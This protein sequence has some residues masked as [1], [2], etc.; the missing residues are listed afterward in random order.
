ML[1]AIAL[2]AVLLAGMWTAS[3]AGAIPIT[4]TPDVVD[5]Q[6]GG[7]PL[8]GTM[9]ITLQSGET[10][11]ATTHLALHFEMTIYD[12]EPVGNVAFDVP[13]LAPLPGYGDGGMRIVDTG[14]PQNA[15]HWEFLGGGP[16]EAGSATILVELA[17]VPT[18]AEFSVSGTSSDSASVSF[19]PIPEPSTAALLG[20][21]LLGLARVARRDA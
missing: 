5:L 9:Q 19:T 11:G 13:V 18:L 15:F 10:D 14:L 17:G 3:A 12:W 6:W 1:R 2:A 16:P 7:Q 4:M 8:G 21:G 20:V